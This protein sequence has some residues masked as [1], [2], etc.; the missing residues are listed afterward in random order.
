MFQ[1]ERDKAAQR[2]S[3][4]YTEVRQV[5]REAMVELVAHLLPLLSDRLSPSKHATTLLLC[6]SN[7]E[8]NDGRHPSPDCFAPERGKLVTCPA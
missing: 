1:H 7:P 5:L 8:S 3:E 2:M 6:T 4:A